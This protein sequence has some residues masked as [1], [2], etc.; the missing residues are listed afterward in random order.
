MSYIYREN[1]NLT[2]QTTSRSTDSSPNYQR[3]DSGLLNYQKVK[4][5]KKMPNLM[6]NANNTPVT[7]NFSIKKIA[8]II[9]NYFF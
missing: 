1:Y 9:K 4:K 3:L 6:K 7:C 8:K 5:K 2:P